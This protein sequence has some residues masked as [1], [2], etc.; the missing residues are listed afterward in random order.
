M[1]H[2]LT[3][4]ATITQ[5]K[6]IAHLKFPAIHNS[7]I[8]LWTFSVAESGNSGTYI[9]DTTGEKWDVSQA[10]SMGFKPGGFQYGIGRYAFTTLDVSNLQS[11]TTLIPTQRSLDESHGR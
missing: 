3:F 8:G 10:E 4:Q 7:T 5:T 1:C 6:N 9:Q 11:A 2:V